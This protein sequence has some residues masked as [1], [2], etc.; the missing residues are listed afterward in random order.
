MPHTHSC[1]CV[2]LAVTRHAPVRL[3]INYTGQRAAGGRVPLPGRWL[4]SVRCRVPARFRRE[5]QLQL[6][7]Q[8]VPRRIAGWGALG[9]LG[10]QIAAASPGSL[11]AK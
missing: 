2:R 5:L 3:P 7:Y 8:L 6:Q 10:V 11:F 4:A 9:A 1:G